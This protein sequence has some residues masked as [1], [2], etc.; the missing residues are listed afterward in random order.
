MRDTIPTT[1]LRPFLA[2]CDV[3]DSNADAVRD[4]AR[5]L[6]SN[7]EG[8]GTVV[9]LF[10][11]V[12]DEVAHTGDAGEGKITSRASDVLRER[13]GLCYAKSHLLV[14]LLRAVSIPAGLCYQRLRYDEA[15]PSFVLHGLVGVRMPD[16]T[17]LRI[18][19]RGNKPGIDVQLAPWREALAF[20]PEHPGEVDLP[21]VF[22]RP[23]PAVVSALAIG[24]IWHP[25]DTHLPDVSPE[26]W[27]AGDAD[28]TSPQSAR[29]SELVTVEYPR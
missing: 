23:N 27:P 10:E 1:D 26:D 24:G 28:W 7:T 16:D 19:P 18:D 17:F 22:A 14:A 2:S 4:L 13:T 8:F 15:T 25:V 5:R 3:I 20:R 11:W 12:R 9:K 6:A 29:E 21:G